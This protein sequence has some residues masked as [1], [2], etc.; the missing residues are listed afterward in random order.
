MILSKEGSPD[1]WVCNIDGS[2]LQ[3]LTKTREDES[4]PCWSPDGTKICYASRVRER[5]GLYIVSSTGGAATRLDTAGEPNP[6]E[7]DW[8]P[9]GSTLVFTGYHADGM[10]LYLIDRATRRIRPL[11]PAPEGGGDFH[12]AWSRARK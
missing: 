11:F 6:S 12:A 2:N 8:S 7:P 10:S 3:Q 1:L 5:R 9:D 4:S